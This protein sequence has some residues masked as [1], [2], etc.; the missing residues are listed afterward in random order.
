MGKEKQQQRAK[1]CQIN[2]VFH[3]YFKELKTIFFGQK[4]HKM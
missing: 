3:L 1:Y 2:T 4:P